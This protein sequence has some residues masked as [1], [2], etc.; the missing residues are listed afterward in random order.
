MSPQFETLD[1]V[2]TATSDPRE[3]LIWINSERVSGAACFAGTR[4]PIKHLWDYLESGESLEDFLEGFPGVTRDQ[5][6]AVLEMA[7]QRLLDS[8]E[9][10]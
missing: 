2:I 1:H 3:G 6:V 10:P 9:Q 7:F 5:A 8:V 4:V